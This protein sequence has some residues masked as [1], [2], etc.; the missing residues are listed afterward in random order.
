MSINEGSR[1]ILRCSLE[2]EINDTL[3]VDSGQEGREHEGWEYEGSGWRCGGK[4]TERNYWKGRNQFQLK[5]PGIYKV[6]PSCNF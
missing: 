1:G 3:W 2:E 4:S 5:L 6:D